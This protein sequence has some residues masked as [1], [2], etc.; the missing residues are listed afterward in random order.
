MHQSSLDSAKKSSKRK[1]VSWIFS[2]KTCWRIFS[3]V[4]RRK[5]YRAN[6][7]DIE[8]NLHLG[9]KN[10]LLQRQKILMEIKICQ[11][12]KTRVENINH[13][14]WAAGCSFSVEHMNKNEEVVAYSHATSWAAFLF[15]FASSV[16]LMQVPHCGITLIMF[17]GK[18]LQQHNLNMLKMAKKV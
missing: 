5:N 7:L 3:S 14:L 6:V 15:L 18:Y 4:C 17:L 8:T 10:K 1:V 12:W 9:N 11:K 13:C 2:L 16:S